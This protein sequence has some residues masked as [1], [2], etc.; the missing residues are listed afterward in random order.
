MNDHNKNIN[1]TEEL[2]AM[3]RTK[4]ANERTLLSFIRTSLAFFAA[5]TTLIQFFEHKKFVI[6]GYFFIPLGFFILLVGVYSYY[7]AIKEM[8]SIKMS[9]QTRNKSN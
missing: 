6:T 7:A 5:A 8:K 9:S 2:L 1:S 4:L 3:E